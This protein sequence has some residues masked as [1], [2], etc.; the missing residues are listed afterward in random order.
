LSE[1]APIRP[2]HSRPPD[3]EAWEARDE[4]TRLERLIASHLRRGIA[5]P[6]T[7]TE[8]QGLLR[9]NLQ[10]RCDYIAKVIVWTA[11]ALEKHIDETDH[12]K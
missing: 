6:L 5:T 8:Q 2:T 1:T 7:P 9:M 4:P 12:S 3:D 11:R 10:Q